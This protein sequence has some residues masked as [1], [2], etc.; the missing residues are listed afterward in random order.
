[1]DLMNLNNPEEVRNYIEEAIKDSERKYLHMKAMYDLAETLNTLL[2]EDDNKDE[3]LKGLKEE[4]EQFKQRNIVLKEL[5]ALII[6]MAE[7]KSDTL[8]SI[9]NITK[10]SNIKWN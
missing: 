10:K 4:L 3:E 1:M 7:S 6:R 8:I 5:G 9:P 2:P